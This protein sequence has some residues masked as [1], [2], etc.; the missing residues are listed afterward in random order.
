MCGAVEKHQASRQDRA[1]MSWGKAAGVEFG[2]V[3]VGEAAVHGGEPCWPSSR[4]RVF[5]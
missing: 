3:V 1:E 5:F 2:E 4:L